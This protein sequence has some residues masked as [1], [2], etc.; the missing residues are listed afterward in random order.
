MITLPPIQD[1]TLLNTGRFTV[2]WMRWFQ[3]VYR[4]LDGQEP[5]KLAKYTLLTLPPV[6]P[7]GML[8]FVTDATGGATT[9]FSSG[10]LWYKSQGVIVS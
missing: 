7:D 4:I 10:G 2:P 6:P 3:L 8:A 5:A 1:L 9:V